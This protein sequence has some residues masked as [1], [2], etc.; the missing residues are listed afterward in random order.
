MAEKVEISNA[1]WEVMRLLWTLNHATSR[2]LIDLK[3]HLAGLLTDHLPE[4]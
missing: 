3:S 2:Q 1:E 4:P